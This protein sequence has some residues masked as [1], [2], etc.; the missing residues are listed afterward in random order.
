[1]GGKEGGKRD[2][3]RDVIS[4]VHFPT[5]SEMSL[6]TSSTRASHS[7]VSELKYDLSPPFCCREEH[8]RREKQ[9][10]GRQKG[11][12]EDRW[13]GERESKKNLTS[14]TGGLIYGCLLGVE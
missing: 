1:M 13:E 3:E 10:G 5:A 8:S 6:K 12:R 9:W 14:G 11:G 2:S 7:V 4:P